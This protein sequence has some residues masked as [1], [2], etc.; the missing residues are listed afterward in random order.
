M[1]RMKQIRRGDKSAG[2]IDVLQRAKGSTALID[3]ER[4]DDREEDNY[5]GDHG[6][7]LITF[8][9]L[10]G[11]LVVQCVRFPVWS[12]AC[13]RTSGLRRCCAK[14]K[15]ELI[16]RFS[17]EVL[18]DLRTTIRSG[19]SAEATLLTD[20]SIA[21]SVSRSLIEVA[22]DPQTSGGLLIALAAD[23]ASELVAA[24]H[25]NGLPAATIV[26]HATSPEETA[27]KLV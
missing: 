15:R 9:R 1:T 12:S 3:D 13:S 10:C 8:S 6:S 22:L 5:R 27:V 20:D 17:R 24:L 21:S 2:P 19:E 7:P 25:A 11:Q 14:F 4:R 26:G 16:I 23:R 18:D